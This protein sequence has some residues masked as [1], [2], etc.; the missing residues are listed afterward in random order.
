MGFLLGKGR[1]GFYACTV[2]LPQK[3]VLET[4]DCAPGV[5]VPRG[6]EKFHSGTEV[7]AVNVKQI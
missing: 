2:P 1:F 3:G 4:L 5:S 6:L 7:H